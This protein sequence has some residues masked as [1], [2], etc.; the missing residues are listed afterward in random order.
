VRKLLELPAAADVPP[1]QAAGLL[2]AAQQPGSSS[3]A[4]VVFELCRG[5]PAA[6]QIEPHDLELLLFSAVVHED[7]V[8]V[9]TLAALPGEVR[10][11][12]AAAEGLMASAKGSGC[13]IKVAAVTRLINTLQ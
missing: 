6:E 1:Q 13:D 12:R 10:V 11:S 9:Q 7:W 3:D 8:R 4:S 2:A 5:L